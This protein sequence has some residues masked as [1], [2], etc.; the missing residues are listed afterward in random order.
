M[1]GQM[2]VLLESIV[3]LM[4]KLIV[5]A[6]VYNYCSADKL[7]I[8]IKNLIQVIIRVIGSKSMDQWACL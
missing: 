5:R 3:L 1:C 6:S 4:L 7:F 8:K 2:T